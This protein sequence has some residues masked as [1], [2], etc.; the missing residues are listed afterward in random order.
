MAGTEIV[1]F[2]LKDGISDAQIL[3]ASDALQRDVQGM[4]GYLARRLLKTGDGQW[5]DVVEW[6]SL[7]AAHRAAEVVMPRPSALRFMDLVDMP[8][9]TVLLA[10]PAT[11]YAPEPAGGHPPAPVAQRGAAGQPC[12]GPASSWP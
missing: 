12:Q 9:V 1:L 11:A 10:R 4:D 7:D 5:I 3:E 6:E 8:S 2:K